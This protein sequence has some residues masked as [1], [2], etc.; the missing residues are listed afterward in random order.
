MTRHLLL[1]ALFTM[2]CSKAKEPEPAPKAVEPPPAP[3]EV[4]PAPAPAPE[5]AAAP[6]ATLD[7][8][9]V[10]GLLEKAKPAAAKEWKGKQVMVTG[11]FL[12]YTHM[13][14]DPPVLTVTITEQPKDMKSR[15]TG[16]IT[17]ELPDLVQ[18]APVVLSGTIDS[19]PFDSPYLSPST[20]TRQ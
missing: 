13:K 5:P 14:T 3:V 9:T 1:A 19:F 2:A 6:A 12:S 10:A 7:P 15:I 17:A 16:V 20:L 4:A 11:Y 18:G 8:F